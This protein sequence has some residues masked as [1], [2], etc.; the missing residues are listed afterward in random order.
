MQ[1]SLTIVHPAN[2]PGTSRKQ[3][4]GSP[5]VPRP[6]SFVQQGPTIG[7]G[8]KQDLSDS[9][10]ACQYGF[11]QQGSTISTSRKQDPYNPGVT[12]KDGPV[13]RGLTIV[14]PEV[15]RNPGR[16][17]NLG[18]SNVPHPN[19]FVQQGPTIGTGRKQDPYNPGVT[20]KDGPVQRGL[21][22]VRPEVN[23]NPPQA[24][25]L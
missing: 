6:N 11:V 10:V 3:N 15:N 25:H 12:F 24:E 14:R 5:N 23:R 17:Q 22:I 13:Q 7:T 19:S 2:Q 20:F 1:W 9:N 21:T 8:C 4:L 18:S 16:K